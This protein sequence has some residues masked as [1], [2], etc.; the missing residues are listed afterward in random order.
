MNKDVV[1]NVTLHR[2]GGVYRHI[3][4]VRIYLTKDFRGRGLGT[5]MLKTLIDIARKEGL[6]QLRA[7][8]FASRPKA[9]RAFESLGFERQCVMEDYFMLADS[10]TEDIAL[11]SMRLLKRVDEF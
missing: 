6:H 5:A 2:R 8:V 10:Q 4:E 3:A 1:G 11:L 9:I 7:E